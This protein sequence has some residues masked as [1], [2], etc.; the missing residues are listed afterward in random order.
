MW[1]CVSS[2]IQAV[3]LYGSLFVCVCVRC[4]CLCLWCTRLFN[5]CVVSVSHGVML[6]GVCLFVFV[7]ECF[8]CLTQVCVLCLMYCEMVY[9]LFF[10]RCVCSCMFSV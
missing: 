8:C 9:G 1:L 4:V 5:V 3:V 10:V 2:V 7:R 6:C